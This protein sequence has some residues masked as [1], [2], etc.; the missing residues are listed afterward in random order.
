VR[1][2]EILLDL[3]ILDRWDSELERM[4]AGK[5]GGRYVYPEVFVRLLGYMRLLFHLPYRQTEGFLKALRRFDSRIHVPDYSTIDRRV[6]RL[7]VKLDEEDY[8][9]DLVLAVDGSGIKVSNRG[10]WI[11]HK[12]K[13]KRGYLKIH[14]AVD[15]KQKKILALKVTDEKVGDGRML[16]PLVEEASRKG[17]KIAKTVADGAYDA[18]SNLKGIVAY[19]VGYNHIDINAATERGLYVANCKGS[20]AEAVAE[21]AVTLMLDIS[22]LAHIGDRFIRDGEWR[23]E[24]S[25]E[26]PSVL[27]GKELAKKTLGLVGMGEIGTRVARIAKGF[28]MKVL[29]FD[30]YLSPEIIRQVGA[31]PADLP[32]L[33]RQSDYVSVHAP[34]SAETRHL[35]GEKEIELMKPTAYLINTARG[36]VVD[37]KALVTALRRKKIAGAGLDVFAVEPLPAHS[38]L[39]KLDNV[40][41]TPHIGGATEEAVAEV[42]RVTAEECARIVQ[43]EVPVNLVNRKELAAKGIRA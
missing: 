39:L 29:V 24:Q 9:D 42:S 43:R 25:G 30:P 13:V 19:G 38:P 3:R 22:R 37:E 32:S 18:K 17:G 1:R 14:I 31:E 21:L 26:L 41:L 40:V 6:N 23:S 33:I 10:D 27:K 12:W 15:V 36:A 4:N 34:L 7:D 2:G 11:R 8:G 16:Q 35:I 5:E 20:N 28:D